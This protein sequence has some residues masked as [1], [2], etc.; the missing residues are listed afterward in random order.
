MFAPMP[1]FSWLP[2]QGTGPGPEG[3]RTA[4]GA[5]NSRKLPPP[6]SQASRESRAA[7]QFAAVLA[8]PE[9]PGKEGCAHEALRL[10]VLAPYPGHHPAAHLG[11]YCVH[12]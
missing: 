3:Q 5:N 10:R 7:G 4:A 12:G 2:G 6:L 8:V 9:P 11:R 1:R